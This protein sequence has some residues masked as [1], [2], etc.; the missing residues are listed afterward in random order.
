MLLLL[1][2]GSA[3][4]DCSNRRPPPA[5]RLFVSTSVDAAIEEMVAKMTNDTELACI[6]SNTLPNTLDTTITPGAANPPT[7]AMPPMSPP[8][9]V[10]ASYT[11]VITG[12][13]KAMWLRDST[14][15]VL[16][17]L[18]YAK[19]DAALSQMLAGVVRQQVLQ[20]L[21][22]PFANAHYLVESGMG[23]GNGDDDTS[24]PSSLC[25]KS[26][27][28]CAYA[29]K[30]TPGMQPGIYERKYELDS[31]MA[32]L[33]LGRSLHEATDDG[34][35]NLSD[36]FDETWMAAVTRVLEV[37]QLEQ[38]SSAEDAI[39]PC[40]PAYTFS[41]SNLAGQGP[42]DTLL[43]G[44]GHPAARTGM[45]RSS[46]RPSDDA[47]TFAFLIP[48][49][50]MAVVEL[51]HT[52]TLLRTLE[53]RGRWSGLGSGH[54]AHGR[55]AMSERLLQATPPGPLAMATRCDNLAS[56]IDAGIKRYGIVNRPALGGDVYAYEVDGFGNALLMDDANVPSLLS[57]PWLGYV[58]SNDPVYV[59]TRAYILSNSSNPWFFRG[60]AG[61][62]VG[63]PHTGAFSI[64]PMALIMRALTSTSEHEIAAQMTMLKSAA[65][66][67]DA[68][69]MHESF[70]MDDANTF[71]RPWFAWANS[72]FASLILTLS[73]ER[74]HLVGISPSR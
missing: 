43:K 48:A 51:R 15:Q 11:F 18:P 65:G 58:S 14:N 36:P 61:E 47:C 63:G 21:A 49:N 52:A 24:S 7:P 50:A 74:P 34:R 54:G 3:S 25:V 73:K 10:N 44:V 13:I 28:D 19:S 8:S 64:W 5:E 22:D 59:R 71:T 12:D 26:S 53:Q 27:G 37:L 41:R 31:L 20:V 33:K 67:P 16:P 45:V 30:R 69:L 38:S 70:N 62:G 6:F 40:G 55:R 35:P 9:N 42:L 23:T 56:E 72:M 1:L 57:L 32:F 17:Y 68:W 4:A 46:F 39:G 66:A 60:R 29:G 2:L